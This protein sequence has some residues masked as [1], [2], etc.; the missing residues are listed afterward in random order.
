MNK[1]KMQLTYKHQQN[2]GSVVE[3]NDLSTNG[4]AI[5]KISFSVGFQ[6]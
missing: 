4:R 6:N 5:A 3:R 1:T 2:T